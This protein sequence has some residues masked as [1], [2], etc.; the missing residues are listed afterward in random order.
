MLIFWKKTDRSHYV[1]YRNLRK[2]T[3]FAEYRANHPNT[4]N[5][6]IL[7]TNIYI[8]TSCTKIILQIRSFGQAQPVFAVIHVV[9]QN[10]MV[11]CIETTPLQIILYFTPCLTD[12]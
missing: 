11:E 4:N 10:I 1:K 2:G 3:V 8:K 7:K 6:E 9:M 12:K 5:G